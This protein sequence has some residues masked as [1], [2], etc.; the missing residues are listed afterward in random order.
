MQKLKLS[1]DCLAVET[2]ET[3]PAA[4]VRRGTVQ[5]HATVTTCTFEYYPTYAPTCAATC[6][7]TCEGSCGNSCFATCGYTCDDASCVSCMTR[8]D[9]VSCVVNHCP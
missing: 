3:V 2:F 5:A 4:A 6:D 7:Y 1:L 9:Q 8:C